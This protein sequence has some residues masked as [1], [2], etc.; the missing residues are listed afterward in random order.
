MK[1]EWHQGAP[2][3]TGWNAIYCMQTTGFLMPS[4]CDHVGGFQVKAGMCKTNTMKCVPLAASIGE[5][6]WQTDKLG[7]AA[8]WA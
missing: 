6:A 3:W 2:A 1:Q 8:L 7:Q 5:K 4:L